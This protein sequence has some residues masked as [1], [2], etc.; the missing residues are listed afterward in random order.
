V[1]CFSFESLENLRRVM[2][3]ILPPDEHY[4]DRPH[5]FCNSPGFSQRPR[6]QINGSPLLV[7]FLDTAED[8]H[9]SSARATALSS[10]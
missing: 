10:L 2:V 3:I 9:F 4:P 8:L 7:F 5:L 1:I 6:V